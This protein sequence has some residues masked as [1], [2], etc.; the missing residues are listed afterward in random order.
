M[1]AEVAGQARA[2]NASG[3]EEDG[4][5]E[6]TRPTHLHA[7][8]GRSPTR[9]PRGGAGARGET[10]A[11][12]ARSAASPPRRAVRSARR[13][14]WRSARRSVRRGAR[15]GAKAYYAEPEPRRQPRQRRTTLRT[16]TETLQRGRGSPQTTGL[17]GPARPGPRRGP[18]RPRARCSGRR[19]ARAP[20]PTRPAGGRTRK[21]GTGREIKIRDEQTQT[22]CTAYNS[23]N[24][25]AFPPYS[26]AARTRQP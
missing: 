16:G 4:A 5:E 12:P 9:L 19:Q 20:R 25:S 17:L 10:T 26:P 24:K 21:G 7:R 14:A 18:C 22:S 2:S 11:A 23:L 6:E 1:S 13:S 15:R 3:K 8:P